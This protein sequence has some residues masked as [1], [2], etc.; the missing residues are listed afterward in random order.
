MTAC[1]F[2]LWGYLKDRVFVPPLPRD[3]EELKTRIREAAATVTE[4]MLKRV[5]EEFGYLPNLEDGNGS[6]A[7]EIF[8][9]SNTNEPS[10]FETL[11][12]GGLKRSLTV[13]DEDGQSWLNSM[14]NKVGISSHNGEDDSSNNRRM[15]GRRIKTEDGR[16]ME[17]AE[18]KWMKENGSSIIKMDGRRRMKVDGRRIK[19]EDGRRMEEAELKWMEEEE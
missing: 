16:R 9:E 6:D 5:W 14:L 17:E 11:Q 12:G 15:D 7:D 19:T 4:D 18:W 13:L 3:L 8:F 2:F 1:D 10:V